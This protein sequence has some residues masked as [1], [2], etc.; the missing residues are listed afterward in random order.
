[1]GKV[2]G[3]PKEE[4]D[5][6]ATKPIQEHDTNS[7]SRQIRYVDFFCEIMKLY[8]RHPTLLEEPQKDYQ[9][10]SIERN[11]FEDAFDEIEI[12]GILVSFSPFDWL[13]NGYRGYF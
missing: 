5:T 7:V 1:M 9:L 12:L 2:F 3:L 13:Q 8:L 4:M 10:P 11:R 6:L